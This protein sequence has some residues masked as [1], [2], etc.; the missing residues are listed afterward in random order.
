MLFF[1]SFS[2]TGKGKNING[3]ERSPFH[4]AHVYANFTPPRTYALTKSHDFHLTNRSFSEEQREGSQ[5]SDS[6][7]FVPEAGVDDVVVVVVVLVP[8]ALVPVVAAVPFP[9]LALLPVNQE[10]TLPP[11]PAGPPRG[12]FPGDIAGLQPSCVSGNSPMAPPLRR[13]SSIA[14]PKT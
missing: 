14:L 2:H 1:P 6:S 8:V 3:S 12:A 11:G 5:E 4:S 9:L 7:W 10:V 13:N